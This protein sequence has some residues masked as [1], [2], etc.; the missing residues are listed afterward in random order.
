MTSLSEKYILTDE[1]LR[2]IPKLGCYGYD[3]CLVCGDFFVK[4]YNRG[5]V[6][7]NKLKR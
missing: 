3:Y 5:G 4:K 6:L 7:T 2:P 1:W